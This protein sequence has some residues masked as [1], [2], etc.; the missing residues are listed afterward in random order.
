MTGFVQGVFWNLGISS[1]ICRF[2]QLEYTNYTS[3]AFRTKNK[4]FSEDIYLHR[5]KGEK[6]KSTIPAPLR[7]GSRLSKTTLPFEL[8][9]SWC[10]YSSKW[11]FSLMSLCRDGSFMSGDLF[12]KW[13]RHTRTQGRG[14]KGLWKKRQDE[15][16]LGRR[17]KANKTA[18]EN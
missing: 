17:R 12:G 14:S 13:R 11:N 16:C 2:K 7:T 5:E 1:F 3:F 6:P 10:E 15:K 18:G 8:G 9:E 4:H